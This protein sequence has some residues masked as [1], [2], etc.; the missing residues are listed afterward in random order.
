MKP[1]GLSA[2]A[3]DQRVGVQHVSIHEGTSLRPL[4]YLERGEVSH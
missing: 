4:L 2:N 3:L 1:L